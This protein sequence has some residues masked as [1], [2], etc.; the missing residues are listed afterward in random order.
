MV[1]NG[2]PTFR[3]KIYTM[4]WWIDQLN[5]HDLSGSGHPERFNRWK[6]FY[7]GNNLSALEQG[8]FRSMG[9]NILARMN[10]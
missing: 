4:W 6:T 3:E 7:G 2:E 5:R 1:A 8:T 9:K 10:F